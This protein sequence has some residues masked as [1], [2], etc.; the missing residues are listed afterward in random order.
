MLVFI[1]LLVALAGG[2]FFYTQ[3]Q[4]APVDFFAMAQ[5]SLA[6]SARATTE[7]E[8]LSAIISS[9]YAFAEIV[10]AIEDEVEAQRALPVLTQL[11]DE[12]KRLDDE[13]KRDKDARAAL[14]ERRKPEVEETAN[15][16]ARMML[17]TTFKIKITK[18]ILDPMEGISSVLQ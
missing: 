5:P 16:L 2:I 13:L 1:G 17:T 18:V 10:G 8:R 3:Q 15:V 7:D 12:A 11:A 4:P 6:E 14:L 9:T